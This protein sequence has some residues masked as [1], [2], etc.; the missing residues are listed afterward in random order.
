MKTDKMTLDNPQNPAT[1][2]M[3]Y[4]RSSS[5]TPTASD[6][7]DNST[8]APSDGTATYTMSYASTNY[9][10]FK[11]PVPQREYDPQASVDRSRNMV[12]GVAGQS[13]L[14]PLLNYSDGDTILFL[15]YSNNGKPRVPQKMR[16]LSERLLSTDSEVFKFL[17]NARSQE[18]ILKRMVSQKMLDLPDGRLPLG[19]KYV[20]DLT[21]EEEGE[22][23]VEWVEKL[24]CPPEIMKWKS[25]LEPLLPP[26][27]IVVKDFLTIIEENEAKEKRRQLLSIPT[28]PNLNSQPQS[29]HQAAHLERDP[30]MTEE[31]REQI[32]AVLD[33]SRRLNFS[34][35][36]LVQNNQQVQKKVDLEE[37]Y[38]YNRHVLSLHRLL[39]LLHE[40]EAAVVSSQ[41]WYT[42]HCLSVAFGTTDATRDAIACWLYGNYPTIV[43]QHPDLVWN[44]AIKAGLASI[45]ADAWSA[46]V[47]AR[48]L[49]STTD[50]SPIYEIPGVTEGTRAFDQRIRD[51]FRSLMATEKLYMFSEPG[52]SD[53]SLLPEWIEQFLPGLSYSSK[54]TKS[55]LFATFA[56]RLASYLLFRLD[57]VYKSKS[58]RETACFSREFWKDIKYLK[59]W[60]EE[61]PDLLLEDLDKYPK[62]SEMKLLQTIQAYKEWE[63]CDDDGNAEMAMDWNDVMLMKSGI[64]EDAQVSVDKG[65]SKADVYEDDDIEKLDSVTIVSDQ[66]TVVTATSSLR[67]RFNDLGMDETQPTIGDHDQAQSHKRSKFNEEFSNIAFDNNKFE[68]PLPNVINS[69]APSQEFQ[70]IMEMTDPPEFEP[71]TILPLST[72]KI[73][74]A[75]IDPNSENPEWL[76]NSLMEHV[77]NHPHDH[78]WGEYLFGK[79]KVDENLRILCKDCPAKLYFIGP[80]LSAGNFE[81]HLRLE[82]HRY[83]VSQR[84]LASAP[85]L[86][87]KPLT[88]YMGKPRASKVKPL[89]PYDQLSNCPTEL[90][91]IFVSCQNHVTSIATSMLEV[92]VGFELSIHED[93]VACLDET[94]R[95][96]MPLW[97]GGEETLSSRTDT[98]ATN[99]RSSDRAQGNTSQSTTSSLC[100]VVSSAGVGSYAGS[101][102]T[103]ES[104]VLVSENGGSISDF[105]DVG[106]ED[107]V[108]HEEKSQK[109][110]ATKDDREF[111]IDEVESDEDD[112]DMLEDDDAFM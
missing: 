43:E 24:W 92:N 76:N 36:P 102:S 82:S 79:P 109:T 39:Y 112:F 27:D 75:R 15:T 99:I 47:I 11:E 2:T 110:M 108:Q 103:I 90:A 45:A 4:R 70:F 46:A 10:D 100:G 106:Y 64:H 73:H 85:Q 81:R 97:A 41:D 104:G 50:L 20:L 18:R 37:P 101:T 58:N 84:L 87:P 53:L 7:D 38:L 61:S 71:Y 1:L 48:S 94:E 28:L 5:P 98:S 34:S 52:S 95:K 74:L 9:G 12:Q 63:E 96:F 49:A 86:S 22:R 107:T 35:S 111:D 55:T 42:L 19:I 30:G 105:S 57:F 93:C 29:Q 23:A 3:H 44:I 60:N 59:L 21:P 72:E 88:D 56:L 66:E 65:K 26:V 33:E 6:L 16:V 40:E 68:S 54:S 31:E 69:S 14:L 91:H 80:G 67:R 78:F 25:L 89:V 62:S 17:L 8:V 83:R 32:L 51:T 77:W 13:S